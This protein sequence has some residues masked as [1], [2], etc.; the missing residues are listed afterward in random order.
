MCFVVVVYVVDFLA[1]ISEEVSFAE[2][3][4]FK[5]VTNILKRASYVVVI[6]VKKIIIFF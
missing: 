2:S 4:F 5:T 3:F 6:V 1:S